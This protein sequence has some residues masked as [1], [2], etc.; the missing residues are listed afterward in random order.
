[1]K[2]KILLSIIS[3]LLVLAGTIKS[4][5]AGYKVKA[6]F[7]EQATIS[8][9]KLHIDIIK[10]EDNG[11]EMVIA[12]GIVYTHAKPGE[13]A[14]AIYRGDSFITDPDSPNNLVATLRNGN[15]YEMYIK[16]RDAVAQK[17]IN[18]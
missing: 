8:S 7:I 15:I 14:G 1:M 17:Q 13:A 9:N 11:E 3:L 6:D 18:K 12:S 16:Q 10:V 5:A 4:L 2:K